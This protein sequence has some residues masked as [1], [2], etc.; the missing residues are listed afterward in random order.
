MDARYKLTCAE[1]GRCDPFTTGFL[2]LNGRGQESIDNALLN[3]VFNQGGQIAGAGTNVGGLVMDVANMN[4]YNRV[5][6][7]VKG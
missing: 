6:N 4:I 7:E 5:I 2:F 1:A 3:L